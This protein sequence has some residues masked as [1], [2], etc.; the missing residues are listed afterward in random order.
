MLKLASRVV[1][2]GESSTLG[3]YAFRMALTAHADAHLHRDRPLAD[4][5]LEW[6]VD[7]IEVARSWVLAMWAT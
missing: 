1:S 7:P 3:D 5:A 6:A 4:L 2:I